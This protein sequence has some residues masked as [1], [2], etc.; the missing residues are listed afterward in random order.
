MESCQTRGATWGE[1][2]VGLFIG[3]KTDL[4]KKNNNNNNKLDI[5]IK[6]EDESSHNKSSQWKNSM[7][8]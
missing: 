6:P 8:F 5:W 4:E 1:P 7:S 3:I 2:H